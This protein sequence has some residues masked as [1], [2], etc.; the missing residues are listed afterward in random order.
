MQTEEEY[1]DE[2]DEYYTDPEEIAFEK[3][4]NDY[5]NIEKFAEPEIELMRF[6]SETADLD[7]QMPMMRV[8]EESFFFDD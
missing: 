3:S 6:E 8:E 2:D 4:E 5:E 1:Y 7:E